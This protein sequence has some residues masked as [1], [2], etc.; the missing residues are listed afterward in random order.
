MSVKHQIEQS[1]PEPQQPEIDGFRAQH[2]VLGERQIV[3]DA[4][5][6]RSSS[7]KMKVRWPGLRAGAGATAGQ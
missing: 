4:G 3:T 5:R 2:L 1:A 6:T 7:M